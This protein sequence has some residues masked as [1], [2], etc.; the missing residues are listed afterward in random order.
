MYQDREK[1]IGGRP[2]LVFIVVRVLLQWLVA[3]QEALQSTLQIPHVR[4]ALREEVQTS[5]HH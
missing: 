3:L 5:Q 1:G 4:P 2:L